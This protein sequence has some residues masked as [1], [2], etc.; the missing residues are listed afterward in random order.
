M[1]PML[2]LD[3]ETRS[4]VDLPKHGVYNYAD[5]CSILIVS[6]K[7]GAG[8]MKRWEPW[9]GNG[10]PA[11]L[12]NMLADR[13]LR[14]MAHNAAFER[15]VL[16]AHKLVRRE[17]ISRWYCTATQARAC[18]MPAALEDLP[19]A[20]G[21]ME[22]KD[23]EGAALMRALS[24]PDKDGNFSDDP[25]KLERYGVYCDRDVEAMIAAHQSM[26][27]MDDETLETYAVSEL[28]NDR[29]LPID[30][31]LC[32]YAVKY[33]EQEKS[34]AN[35]N[36]KAVTN[37]ACKTAKGTTLTS[38]VYERLGAEARK[39]M[40]R[41]KDG[42][43]TLSLDSETRAALMNFAE[44]DPDEFHEGALEAIEAAE[45]AAAASIAKFQRMKNMASPDGRL[46]G[47]FVMNGAS[48]TGRFAA[49]GAQLH[50][51]PRKCAKNPEEIK[52]LMAKGKT[53]P[54]PVLQVLKSMLR[55]A[56]CSPNGVIVRGDWNAVEARGLPWLSN[57]PAAERYLDAFRD[58]T[59]DVYVEQAKASGV[60]NRETGEPDRQGGKVV[61]LS[62]G[63]GGAD[64]ALAM[65]SKAYGVSIGDKPLVVKRWRS[66]NR[67]AVKLWFD[68]F[69]AFRLA[70][71]KPQ[72]WFPAGRLAFCGTGGDDP[73]VCMRLPSG[74]LLY[75]PMLKTDK[76]DNITYLKAAW[77][78]KADAK[79]WPHAKLWYGTVIENADQG[80]CADLLRY[81]L[82]EGI[83][84]GLPIIGHM[85][86]EI[87]CE[88]ATKN[89]KRLASQLE[90]HMMSAPPWAKGFPLA[91]ETDVNN[92]FRK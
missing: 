33:A 39:M 66:A 85:H 61:V 52:A 57:T 36:I 30:T 50:N 59:R 87:I 51:F 5:D 82:V 41:K 15:L 80:S 74:R 88:T 27:P 81:N 62:L 42:K 22:R 21:I 46:R 56:I 3:L 35:A 28:I 9:R 34:E 23:H 12:A 63:F 48:G 26:P 53:L 18:A 84:A 19:R 16:S 75:Y 32:E 31:E 14:L 67:W 89:G 71:R 29:G 44:E 91:V 70:R 37:G 58:K 90:K 92:R 65:M 38:W 79:E 49:R 64:G 4:R 60:F 1:K 86:D 69:D 7:L 17:D 2:Q 40:E 73:T 72:Q 55:A 47:A 83:K 8:K 13:K 24:I 45:A 68:A 10:I 6:Y 77:K 11:D 20:L 76:T 43:N 25:V 78:P 54:G